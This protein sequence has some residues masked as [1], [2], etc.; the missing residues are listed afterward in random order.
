MGELTDVDREMS[1]PACLQEGPLGSHVARR[2]FCGPPLAAIMGL[3]LGVAP[4]TST[5]CKGNATAAS[6]NAKLKQSVQGMA[7]RGKPPQAN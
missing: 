2:R 6:A 7:V 1:L 5:P 4:S 3:E